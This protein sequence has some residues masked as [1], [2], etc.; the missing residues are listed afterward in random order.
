MS[1]DS[2]QNPEKIAVLKEILRQ[3]ESH[4]NALSQERIA[5]ESRTSS[6]LSWMAVLFIS[7]LTASIYLT[8][9][10]SK[11][12]DSIRTYTNYVMS[13]AWGGFLCAFITTAYGLFK[14]RYWHLVGAVP[15]DLSLSEIDTL[16][17]TI[18]A[19]ERYCEDNSKVL[20]EMRIRI[21]VSQR[22]IP[23]A[24]AMAA[25]IIIGVPIAM[26]LFS[27]FYHPG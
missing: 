13:F 26:S 4:L 10:D 21:T 24:M 2:K 5:L 14:H 15:H 25:A 22:V 18:R 8:L 3:R 12:P 20:A 11:F 9:P 7:T 6:S 19:Y 16:S 1:N 27:R 17:H 23:L